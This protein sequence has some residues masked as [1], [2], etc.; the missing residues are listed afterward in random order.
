MKLKCALILLVILFSCNSNKV[1]EPALLLEK[2][3]ME[4]IMYDIAILQGIEG[5][6]PHKLIENN[7]NP[8]DYIY[9]KYKIDSLTYFENQRFYSSQVKEYNDMTAAVF[10]RLV[11]KK[12]EIDT[13]VKNMP[14]KKIKS[15]VKT[16]RNR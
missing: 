11:A 16:Q 4:N 10:I 15:R 14:V 13:I 12:T 8:S 7:I 3:T 6:Q 5:N 9:Q 1:K 2:S